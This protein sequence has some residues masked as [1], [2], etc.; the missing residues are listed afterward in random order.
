MASGWHKMDWND[1]SMLQDHYYYLVTIPFFETPMKAKW[2]SEM[3]G[4]WEV[5]GVPMGNPGE[6]GCTYHYEWEEDDDERVI[7]WMEMPD[8]YKEDSNDTD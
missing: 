7:A 6:C 2:H 3:G 5:F 8:V 4:H 1:T